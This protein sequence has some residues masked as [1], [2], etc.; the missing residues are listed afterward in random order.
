VTD[1]REPDF[2]ALGR[3]LPELESGGFDFGRW[4]GGQR[5]PG[6]TTR[7][8][9]FTFSSKALQLVRDLPV[10]VF[11]WSAWM[12]TDEA[13]A[14]IADH[15]HIAHATPEQ[16]VKLCTSLLR[17]DRFNEGQLAWAFESGLLVEIVRRA[18]TLAM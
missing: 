12:H 10:K 18:R 7:M 1:E 8:P 14:L 11:D 2:A 16:L 17:S 4:E 13:K 15:A 3:W 6:G 9:Y 5:L